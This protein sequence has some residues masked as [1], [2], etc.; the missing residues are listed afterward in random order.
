MSDRYKVVE[1]SQ[2]AHCCFSA[3]VIDSANEIRS[4]D[5]RRLDYFDAV[6]ECISSIDAEFVARA[7][8]EYAEKRPDR[9]RLTP[10]T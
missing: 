10:A 8:N 3:T 1:G 6:C 5:G 7:L 4:P 9:E 2:S